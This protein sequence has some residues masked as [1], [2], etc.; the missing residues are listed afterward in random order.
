MPLVTVIC[1][2][3]FIAIIT[4]LSQFNVLRAQYTHDIYG[5][6]IV[7]PS[8]VQCLIHQTMTKPASA[9]TQSHKSATKQDIA[10]LEAGLKGAMEALET[11]VY[12]L[13]TGLVSL[14]ERGK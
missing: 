1:C 11:R 14:K 2:L 4:K 5:T 13:H 10:E 6:V 9:D 7:V 3:D 8:M 12:E